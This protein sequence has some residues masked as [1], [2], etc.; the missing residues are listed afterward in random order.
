MIAEKER[1]GISQGKPPN[2]L[3]RSALKPYTYKQQNHT[4][5]TVEI[6]YVCIYV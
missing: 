6:T 4:Q 5:Q 3:Q 2:W 1:I